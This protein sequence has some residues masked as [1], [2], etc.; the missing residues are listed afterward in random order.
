MTVVIDTTELPNEQRQLMMI[1]EWIYTEYDYR[2]HFTHNPAISYLENLRFDVEELIDFLNE[3]FCLNGYVW[4]LNN[5]RLEYN[6]EF[7]R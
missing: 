7:I 6:E 3:N 1:K 4:E 2:G 5:N